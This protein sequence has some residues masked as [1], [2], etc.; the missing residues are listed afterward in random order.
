MKKRGFFFTLD[1]IIAMV[2]LVVGFVLIWA[3]IL[4]ETEQRQPFFYAQTLIDT[5]ST[6]S[7]LDVSNNNLYIQ[8]L[9]IDG[10]IT[11]YDMPVLEQIILFYKNKNKPSA[12]PWEKEML[13]NFTQAVAKRVVVRQ[14]SFALTINEELIYNE[15]TLATPLQNQSEV[16]ISA[17]KLLV[18]VT[19][20][21]DLSGPY[22]AEVRV[23]R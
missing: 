11:D 6:S 10:N 5:L 22:L 23:W 9:I 19:D 17:K 20:Q 3:N 7:N 13:F 2:I 8:Q 12:Q 15:S 21:S 18:L 1:V 14:Y 16:L 4:T